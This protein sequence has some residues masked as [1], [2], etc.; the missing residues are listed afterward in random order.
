MSCHSNLKSKKLQAQV[1]EISPR[2][3]E[4]SGPG[5][6]G[7]SPRQT[8]CGSGLWTWENGRLGRLRCNEMQ[9]LGTRARQT[10][11]TPWEAAVAPVVAAAALVPKQ[12]LAGVRVSGA[13][14]QTVE[15]Q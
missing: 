6:I 15:S 11:M 9:I 10:N 7:A 13:V 3:L 5:S 2:I 14:E 4:R 1:R 12:P 8:Q